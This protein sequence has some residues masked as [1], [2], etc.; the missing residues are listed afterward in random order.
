MDAQ[1][2]VVTTIQLEIQMGFDVTDSCF[3]HYSVLEDEDF[4]TF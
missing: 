3:L 2:L 4:L 1:P